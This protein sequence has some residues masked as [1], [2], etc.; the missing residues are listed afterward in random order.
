M[1]GANQQLQ[2]PSFNTLSAFELLSPQASDVLA[3]MLDPKSKNG[4]ALR[5]AAGGAAPPLTALFAPGQFVRGV[6]IKVNDG[7]EAEEED[8]AGGACRLCSCCIVGVV[9]M[10]ARRRLQC[11]LQ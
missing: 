3:Q 11:R 1:T 9:G 4:A 8:A 5:A 7:G 2:Y 10:V 6:V